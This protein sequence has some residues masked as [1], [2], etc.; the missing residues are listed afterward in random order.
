MKTLAQIQREGKIQ[1]LC[2]HISEI[3]HYSGN[4]SVHPK[5]SDVSPEND[6][7]S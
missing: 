2:E 6:G 1:R 4:N 7:K 3:K 5:A